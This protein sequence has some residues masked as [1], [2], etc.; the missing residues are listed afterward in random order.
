MMNLASGL[1][2]RRFRRQRS[3]LRNLSMPNRILIR[4][5]T[6]NDPYRV[7]PNYWEGPYLIDLDRKEII[8]HHNLDVKDQG[9]GRMLKKNKKG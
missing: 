4:T 5:G 8:W 3:F 1:S 2:I 9:W 7:Q 6:F